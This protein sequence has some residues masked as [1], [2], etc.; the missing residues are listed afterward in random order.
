MPHSQSTYKGNIRFNRLGDRLVMLSWWRAQ[1]TFSR[2][3]VSRCIQQVTVSFILIK[4][5]V[6]R[7]DLLITVSL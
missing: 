6:V 1:N 3:W 2:L 5:F 7:A 4:P